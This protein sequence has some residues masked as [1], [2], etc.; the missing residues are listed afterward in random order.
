MYKYTNIIKSKD[1][2]V[3][4]FE[5]NGLRNHLTDL[6]KLSPLGSYTI[7]GHTANGII[8]LKS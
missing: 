6:K 8:F 5:L 2:I 1:L 3:G 7:C 4:L